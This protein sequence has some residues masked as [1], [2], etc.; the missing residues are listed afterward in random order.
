MCKPGLINQTPDTPLVIF[1]L[2]DVYLSQRHKNNHLQ[3]DYKA[4]KYFFLK[5][6]TKLTD[7]HWSRVHQA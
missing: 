4:D 3:R 5:E 7:I 6:K 1:F 2:L